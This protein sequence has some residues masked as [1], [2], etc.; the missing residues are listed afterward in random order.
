[1]AHVYLGRTVKELRMRKKWQQETFL[2]T[3]MLMQ[4]GEYEEAIKNCEI[5]FHTSATRC[6]G[7]RLFN[8][9]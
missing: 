8:Y 4:T 9:V 1:M 2:G 3:D 6:L 7:K 5:G